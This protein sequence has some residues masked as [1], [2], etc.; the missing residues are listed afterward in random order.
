MRREKRKMLYT[1]LFLLLLSIGIGYAALTTNLSIDGSSTLVAGNWDIHFANISVTN[2]S[3][4]IGTGNS[5]A[6]ITTPTTVT[7]NV[8]LTNP[9]DFYEFTVDVVNAGT[10]DAMIETISSKLNGVEITTLPG[11]L[12]YSVT[13]SDGARLAPNQLLE[14]GNSEK[15]RV[16]IKY[17]TDLNPEDLSPDTTNLTLS[18]SV[19]YIQSDE[20]AIEA[21]HANSFDTDSWDTV[22]GAIQSGI[23][24]PYEVGDEKEVELGN[25]FGTH[26][27]RIVNMSTPSECS[28][29]G[30]SQT[31]CGIVLEFA[32]IITTYKMNPAG[33]YQGVQYDYGFNLGGWPA[34]SLRSYMNDRN[35][36]TS[37]INSL[38]AVIK[39]AIIDTTVVSS[40]GA[41][42]GETNYISTDKLYF[43]SA[44]E[45]WE[46]VDNNV[47][48]GIDYYDTTYHNTRQL[49]YYAGLNI[50]TA[51]SSDVI[52]QYNNENAKWWLRSAS[53]YYETSFYCV[54]DDTGGWNYDSSNTLDGVSPAFRIG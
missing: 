53:L 54:D 16:R 4:A 25:G 14:A 49:D 50:T 11:N 27:I 31:A 23:P 24:V 6:T 12:D 48:I 7:Y 10:I 41:T 30:F 45:I 52:K 15:Y 35:S 33:M 36:S 29:P 43:L 13:Y 40:H 44:H 9:G 8:T 46:D 47:N 19:T 1:M 20:N 51:N 34:T 28:T 26:T 38:P 21:P 17:K 22:I 37:I 5:A 3:V 2:G 18:F 42:A 32:D 39:D